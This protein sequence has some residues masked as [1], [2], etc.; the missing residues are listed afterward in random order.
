MATMCPRR[1]G[2]PR[3]A[4]SSCHVHQASRWRSQASL[5]R[6]CVDRQEIETPGGGGD[7]EASVVSP[8][9]RSAVWQLKEARVTFRRAPLGEAA[10]AGCQG[11]G[12]R[13]GEG[14]V[15]AHTTGQVAARAR[16]PWPR[17]AGTRA[18]RKEARITEEAEGRA[19]SRAHPLH[20]PVSHRPTSRVC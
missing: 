4:R 5:P 20:R 19:G 15:R 2:S 8:P 18:S 3:G 11:Q 12:R 14:V 16:D 1:P 6:L 10:P 9:C 13:P 7:R 17:G